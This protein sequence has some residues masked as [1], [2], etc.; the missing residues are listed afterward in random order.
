MIAV[1]MHGFLA[2]TSECLYESSGGTI[3]AEKFAKKSTSN[4]IDF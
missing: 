4:R 2:S 1:H 3:A